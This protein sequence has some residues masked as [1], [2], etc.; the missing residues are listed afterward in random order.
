MAMEFSHYSQVPPQMQ[1]ELIAK[2]R[3]KQAEKLKSN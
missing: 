3:K 2:H 1:K